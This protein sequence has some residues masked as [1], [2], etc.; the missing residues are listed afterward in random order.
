MAIRFGWTA[1]PMPRS[2][3]R[4]SPMW[5]G[6]YRLNLG[7]EFGGPIREAVDS[8][9]KTELSGT[10]AITCQCSPDD[11]RVHESPRPRFGLCRRSIR[12]LTNVVIDD[13]G[14]TITAGRTT[15][16]S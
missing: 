13:Y 2:G 6:P 7:N 11:N 1:G 15:L 14:R 4:T 9:G 8:L 5:P 16:Y 12:R 10:T 3:S